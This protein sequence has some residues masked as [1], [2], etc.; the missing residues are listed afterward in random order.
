MKKLICLI[1]T[2][3]LV[4]GC[5]PMA[6]FAESV[7]ASSVYSADAQLL[8]VVKEGAPIRSG[9]SQNKDVLVKCGEGAVLE[10]VDTKYNWHGNRWYAVTYS[11]GKACYRG[12]IYSGN[13]TQH[14]CGY[15][16]MDWEGVTYKWCDCGRVT[17]EITSTATVK[18]SDAIA[19]AGTAG[20]TGAVLA[21]GPLP[22]GDF[23]GLGILIAVGLMEQTGVLPSAT[24]VIEV[25]EDISLEE[26]LEDKEEGVCPVDSYRR[27]KRV[28]DSLVY[29]DNKCLNLIEAYLVVS[30]FKEDVY[31]R[32]YE[33]ALTL[34]ML[35]KLGGF[36]EIHDETKD[37]YH[38]FH[39]G[40]NVVTEDNPKGK[41][42]GVE[43]GHIFYGT[44]A[45]TNSI[46]LS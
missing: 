6:A 46:P 23:I 12:Y 19:L 3:A 41:H 22:V 27:V 20:M 1:L 14:S 7:C 18:R 25:T 5:V 40:Q 38:H 4:L 17:V 24:E 35:H 26:Y 16:T 43:G 2:L 45:L 34:A 36:S 32:D 28:G 13:V 8:E 30:A 37:Y 44:S 15:E 29:A 21:D 33:T 39:F 42:V 31:C 9:T 11:D 10:K